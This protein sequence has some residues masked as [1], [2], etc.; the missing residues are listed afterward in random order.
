MEDKTCTFE[1]QRQGEKR[2]DG[3][4]KDTTKQ[5]QQLWYDLTV[6]CLYNMTINKA[7]ECYLIL[8]VTLKNQQTYSKKKAAANL[9]FQTSLNVE[10][11]E[12]NTVI[13]QF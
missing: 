2:E 13:R 11:Q 12:M 6:I 1:Q 7:A 4:R 10:L 9:F 3:K 8:I 5:W